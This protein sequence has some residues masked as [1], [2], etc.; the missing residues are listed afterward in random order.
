M[1]HFQERPRAAL[2]KNGTA[3]LWREVGGP[4]RRAPNHNPK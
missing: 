2:N 4:L 1:E 3:A